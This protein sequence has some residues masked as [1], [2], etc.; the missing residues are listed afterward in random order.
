M[1]LTCG[2]IVMPPLSH[3]LSFDRHYYDGTG[4]RN[5]TD[6]RTRMAGGAIRG[7]PDPPESGRLPDARLAERGGRRRPGSLA[8]TQPLRHEQCR[9]PGRMGGEGRLRHV[10]DAVRRTPRGDARGP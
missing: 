5:V 1:P 6:G 9:E 7:E 2:F 8:A 4:R 10:R 3:R